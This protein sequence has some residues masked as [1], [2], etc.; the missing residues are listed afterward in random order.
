[1]RDLL[2]SVHPAELLTLLL[3]LPASSRDRDAEIAVPLS[4]R[5]PSELVVA[6]PK[7]ERSP[8][9]R[10]FVQVVENC[11]DSTGH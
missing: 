10:S 7:S 4:D 8:L 2:R 3:L 5:R 11:W 1:M 6:W 9:V